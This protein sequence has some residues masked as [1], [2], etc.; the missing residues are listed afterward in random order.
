MRCQTFT[1]RLRRVTVSNNEPLR[2]ALRFVTHCREMPAKVRMLAQF[3]L[4][5]LPPV[6][7]ETRLNR[8]CIASG[9]GRSVIAEFD[10]AR[11]RFRDAALQGKLYGIQKASW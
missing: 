2:K 8:R 1:D 4:A 3:R 6:S 5:E 10:L 11:N 9:W 7:A